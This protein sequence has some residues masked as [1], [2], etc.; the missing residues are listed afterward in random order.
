MRGQI[1]GQGQDMQVFMMG[2]GW[3]SREI[4]LWGEE[5]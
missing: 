5:K 1:P 2:G 4:R 3:R